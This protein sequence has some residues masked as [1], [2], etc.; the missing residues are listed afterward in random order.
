M[1]TWVEEMLKWVEVNRPHELETFQAVFE[2][3]PAGL[4]LMA[5]VGFEAGREYQQAN[6]DAEFGP[7]D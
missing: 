2:D 3:M 7:S 5:H 6:P 4:I 1:P